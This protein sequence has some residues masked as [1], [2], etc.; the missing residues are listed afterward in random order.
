VKRII[1]VENVFIQ[2]CYKVTLIQNVCLGFMN[3]DEKEPCM[4]GLF[5]NSQTLQKITFKKNLPYKLIEDY[6]YSV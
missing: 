4:N 3:L 6:G 5:V 1:I 2:V